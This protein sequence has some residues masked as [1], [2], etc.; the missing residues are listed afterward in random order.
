MTAKARSEVADATRARP[1]Q[2]D[3]LK[4]LPICEVETRLHRSP[5]GLTQA[6]ADKES[7]TNW[8]RSRGRRLSIGGVGELGVPA[9]E[10][11]GELVVEDTGAD[12]QQQVGA[13]G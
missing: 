7:G 11:V 10:V 6:A 12:L 5:E 4:T 3:E 13:A 1:D 8:G 9:V 2:Q